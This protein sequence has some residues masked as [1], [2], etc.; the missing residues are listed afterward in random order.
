MA[1]LVALFAAAMAALAPGI[2]VAAYAAIAELMVTMPSSSQV[3]C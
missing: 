2:G 1:A 3:F